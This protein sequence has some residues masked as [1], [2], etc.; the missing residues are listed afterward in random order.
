MGAW[1]GPH[2]LE[3]EREKRV[4]MGG[5]GFESTEVIPEQILFG[6]EKTPRLEDP[7]TFP[8]ACLST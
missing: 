1:V 3:R 6:T 7:G 2:S 4:C 5:S 8:R